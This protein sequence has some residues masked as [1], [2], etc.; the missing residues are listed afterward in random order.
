LAVKLSSP[1]PVLYRQQRV[2]KGGKLFEML[3]FRSMVDHAEDGTGARWAELGDS[4]VT[5]VGRL[6]RKPHLDELP[7]LWNVIVGHM[8]LVGPRPERPEFARQLAKRSPLYRKRNSVRPGMSGWAQIK[9]PYAASAED[10]EEKLM[11]DLYYI[12]N[13][14]FLLDLSILASTIRIAALGRGAR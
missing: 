9:A 4:R 1:G 3:K 13:L 2:G 7:Q 12:K 14:S 5:T 8:S 6:M 11:Y 10:S